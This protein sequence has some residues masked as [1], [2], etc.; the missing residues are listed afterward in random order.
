MRAV[1]FVL[2]SLAAAPA[3]A[4][5]SLDW[6][7]RDDVN[8]ALP[9]SVRVFEAD[10]PTI[11][12][13]YARADL[14][15]SDWALRAVL[16]DDADGV[17]TV[18]SFAAADDVLVAANGGYYGGGQSFSLVVDRGTA[19]ASNI[20]A[21][22]RSG[23]TFFPTRGAFGITRSGQPEV[24]W[25]YNVDGVQT[26]YPAPSPNA[27]GSPQP[28]PTAAF[29]AGGAPWPV[30]TAIG[31]GPVLVQGGRV[32]P[33]WTEEVFF[34]GSGVDTT[35]TRARTAVG[36]TAAGEMLL[37]V[38]AENR[39]TTLRETGEIL[40][41]LGADWAV[42]LDGGGSSNLIAGGV[43]LYTT[44]RQVASA[45]LLTRPDPAQGTVYDT[46]DAGY[47]ESGGWFESSNTPYYGPTR[48][49]LNGVGSGDDH[50]TFRFGDLVRAE[51]DVEAWWVPAPNRAADTTVEL[52]H[53]GAATTIRVDQSD[54]ATAG[55]WNAL[56][57][58]VLGPG[59]SLRVT[60]AATPGAGATFVVAD[61]V[62]LTRVQGTAASEGPRRGLG[63]RLGPNPARG[64]LTASFRLAEAG[65]VRLR[66]ADVLGRAVGGV[67]TRLGAGPQRL[68]IA[69]AGLPSG[70]YVVRVEAPSGSASRVVT[71]VR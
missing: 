56:G 3:A 40:A 37:L 50:A 32:D 34:G 63:L 8:A 14:A 27:P 31:G 55:R 29:P 12:A 16:S 60:D 64:L 2:L 68:S 21:L 28:R 54:A 53:Q 33:T 23:T 22:N 69:A 5:L 61:A 41:A 18:A 6:A 65:E 71:V 20:A 35:S 30:E 43:P 11:R 66:I 9:A 10:H 46:G 44:A 59:D 19:L 36:Y 24:A 70:A 1:C 13:W 17:E 49:R 58:F 42:N 45:L 39:G 38:V 47:R 7:A 67:T 52:Y 48:A 15:A 26:R 51:Y 4:Q 25:V 62:R 57:R